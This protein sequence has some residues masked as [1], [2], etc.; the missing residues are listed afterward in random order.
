M[1]KLKYAD[2]ELC[3]VDNLQITNSMK[4]VSY[5]D[6]TCDFTDYTKSRFTN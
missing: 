1:I 5:N 2:K 6:I 4:E 3:I